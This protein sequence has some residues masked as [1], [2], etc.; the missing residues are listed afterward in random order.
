MNKAFGPQGIANIA[1]ATISGGL[2]GG[3]EAAVGLAGSAFGPIGALIG[4]VLGSGIRKLFGGK[5]KER[6]ASPAAP[7][8]TKDIE[9]SNQLATYLAVTGQALRGSMGGE[10]DRI[11]LLRLS[12]AS[13]G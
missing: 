13:V 11:G 4:G 7:V 1:G 9:L 10:L 5:K 6:G 8:Y 12:Q 2:G 3:L